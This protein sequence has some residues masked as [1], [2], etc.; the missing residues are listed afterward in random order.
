MKVK[1]KAYV[2]HIQFP[3]QEKPSYELFST[4]LKSVEHYL[5]VSETPIEIEVEVPDN[6]D[7]RPQQIAALEEQKR[8]L[9]AEFAQSV[10]KIDEQIKKYLAIAA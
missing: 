7:P 8:K 4:V 6:F 3:W 5:C 1:I 9:Q 10:A 2:H